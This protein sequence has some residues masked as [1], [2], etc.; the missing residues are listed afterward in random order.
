[1]M[2]GQNDVAG[3]VLDE[4]LNLAVMQSQRV[5][6]LLAR[7]IEDA[8][9]DERDRITD[10][11]HETRQALTEAR[12][13]ARTRFGR[14]MHESWWDRAAPRDV[15][16]TIETALAWREHDPRAQ[17]ACEKIDAEMQARWG[18]SLDDLENRLAQRDAERSDRDAHADTARDARGDEFSHDRDERRAES[19]DRD[20][21]GR[22]DD[23]QAAT[24][25]RT[26][27]GD[28]EAFSGREWDT[29]EAHDA[30]A[31]WWDETVDPESAAAAKAA[32]HT[33]GTHPRA[34]AAAGR[35][36]S[37]TARTKSAGRGKGARQAELGR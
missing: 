26:E 14:V 21:D 25:A 10:H 4:H 16:Q 33:Q 34:A 37:R 24:T 19:E 5:V 7:R 12:D 3:D 22:P 6:E 30:R 36:G 15:A 1:M 32:D 13:A 11:T 31:A 18:V 2:D 28:A 8:R 23:P 35:A 17:V 27:A 9:R 20:H 29:A